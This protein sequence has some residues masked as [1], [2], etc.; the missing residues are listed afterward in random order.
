MNKDELLN[1]VPLAVTLLAPL[2][3]KYG[4]STDDLTSALTGGVG[5]FL[6]VALHWNMKKVPEDAKTVIDP[7]AAYHGGPK[8]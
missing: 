4:F 3:A 8:S 5:I 7:T 1:L 2:A 6:G